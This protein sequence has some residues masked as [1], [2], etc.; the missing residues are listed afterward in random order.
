MIVIDRPW[1][2]QP[3]GIPRLAN[4]WLTRTITHCLP[5]NGCPIELQTGQ[6]L[7]Y[8]TGGA[9]V[10]TNKGRALQGSGAAA[11]ASVAVDLKSSNA[12]SFSFWL[13]WDAFANDD[14]MALEFTANAV[15]N[16]GF[17]VNPNSGAP[18][19]G[20]FAVASG[21]AGST[22][23]LAGFTRPA[24]AEWH[25]YA[26]S[27]TRNLG[28]GVIA[29][30]GYLDGKP[31]SLSSYGTVANLDGAFGS[32]TLYLLSRAGT[33]LYGLGKIFNVV[34]RNNHVITAAEAL[35]EAITPWAIYAPRHLYI[36]DAVA[37][38]I[39]TISA[40]TYVPG[41]LTSTGWRPQVTAT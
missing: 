40:S 38:T 3:Q 27:C 39:P 28:A 17:Y 5:L 32:S 20:T 35:A 9:V 19:S 2:N 21:N 15:S 11:R 31:I 26:F 29:W 10:A 34:I 4:N 14:D 12:V 23:N 37:S 33:S 16:R 13:N 41:S 24:A 30:S 25:H 7:T 8:G 22:Y 36:P 18:A 6:F 1:V